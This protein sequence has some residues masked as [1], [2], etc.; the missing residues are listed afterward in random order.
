MANPEHLAILKQGVEVWNKW[1][2][3]TR[4]LQPDLRGSDLR[5]ADLSGADLRGADLRDAD[6]Y[7]ANMYYANLRRA[8]LSDALLSEAD[9]YGADLR[10]AE[11]D[12]ANLDNTDLRAADLR[13]VLNLYVFKLRNASIDGRT[14]FSI[15]KGLVK[16]VNGI[17][18]KNLML[19]VIFRLDPP[20]DSMLSN[21]PDSIIESLKSARKLHDFSLAFAGIAVLILVT[22][23][24]SISL[25][26]F[27]QIHVDPV[28]F[29]FIAVLFS[30]GLLILAESFMYSAYEA[31]QYIDSRDSAMTV[32]HFPWTLSKYDNRKIG[33]W[34]TM[35][36]R[37]FLCAHP[38]IYAY[39]FYSLYLSK[40]IWP[41]IIEMNMT[42]PFI[43]LGTVLVIYLLTLVYSV[44][45]FWLSQKFQKPILFD[46]E[47]ERNRKSEAAILNEKI[48]ELIDILKPKP[49]STTNIA[50]EVSTNESSS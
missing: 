5:G 34:I 12:K 15:N 10:K 40:G 37:V 24:K 1:R 8:I 26:F 27:A 7:K 14:R 2:K 47:T 9:L 33:K 49:S 13:N 20:G 43:F 39:F 6:L 50:E 45:I 11:L 31:A 36:F 18:D 44:R 30:V 46:P 35:L 19:A 3:E 28:H 4:I 42:G 48:T 29:L 25:P 21:N 17:Y 32:G 22:G 38:L 41:I 23:L 16:G